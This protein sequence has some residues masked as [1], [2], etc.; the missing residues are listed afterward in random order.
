MVMKTG[1]RISVLYNFSEGFKIS[2]G[3][4]H[5]PQMGYA[6]LLFGKICDAN[7]MKMKEI[8]PYLEG[9]SI[10]APRSTSTVLNDIY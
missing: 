3:R 6:N 5:Q 1:F 4:V 2:P 9:A 8:K 7:C 10:A